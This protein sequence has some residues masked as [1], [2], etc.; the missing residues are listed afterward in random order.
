VSKIY[1]I[2]KKLYLRYSESVWTKGHVSI[3]LF[4]MKEM[5]EQLI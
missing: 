5:V 2:G 1:F 3:H 4:G